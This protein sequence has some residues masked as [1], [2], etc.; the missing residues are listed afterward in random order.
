MNDRKKPGWTRENMKFSLSFP[1]L[2]PL[3]FNFADL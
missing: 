2:A 1:I 3:N